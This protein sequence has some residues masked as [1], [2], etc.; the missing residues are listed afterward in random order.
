LKAYESTGN[1]LDLVTG[2]ELVDV[3]TTT[4][5][6]VGVTSQSD[7]SLVAVGLEALNS[8]VAVSLVAST[9]VN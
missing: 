7:Y 9:T 8:I 2:N 3:L 4:L 6:I 1:S 5:E